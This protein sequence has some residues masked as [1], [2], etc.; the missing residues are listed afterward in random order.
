MKQI[1]IRW[2]LAALCLALLVPTAQGAMNYR[3]YLVQGKFAESPGQSGIQDLPVFLDDENMV[4]ISKEDWRENGERYLCWWTNRKLV[5]FLLREPGDGQH[6]FIPRWDGSCGVLAQVNDPEAEKVKGPLQLS[7]LTLYDW[8]GEDLENPRLI[9][10]GYL[11]ILP[12]RGGFAVVRKDHLEE[13]A[14]LCLYDG[15]GNSEGRFPLPK[16][17]NTIVRARRNADGLW[18]VTVDITSQRYVYLPMLIR[19]GEILWQKKPGMDIFEVT[20]DNSGG[21]FHYKYTGRDSET[22]KPLEI[23]RYDGN[24]QPLWKKTLKGNKVL[25][26]AII[27]ENPE[28]GKLLLY[29]KATA[30]SRGVFRVFRLELDGQGNTLSLDV[31]ECNYY[32]SYMY[33]VYVSPTTGQ[34]QVYLRNGDDQPALVPF[35]ALPKAEN[36]GL[37]FR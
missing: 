18:A 31:R 12:T 30:A 24:A 19:N 29:G 23:T 16:D 26:E 13:D 32:N 25:L 34:A 7:T 9:D 21:F 27:W 1:A 2:L 35:D 22:Y 17:Y 20:P 15:Q 14:T 28:N 11:D 4:G 10:K 33:S 8:A 6:Q 5:H 3:A 37:S 36:P